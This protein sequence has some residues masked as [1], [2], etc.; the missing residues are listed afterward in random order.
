[1]GLCTKIDKQIDDF[2]A[3]V[4]KVESFSKQNFSESYNLLLLIFF[5]FGIIKCFI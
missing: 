3:V 2:Y 4:S 1:M 5:L